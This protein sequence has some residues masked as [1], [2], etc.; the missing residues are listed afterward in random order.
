VNH[1]LAVEGQVR[2]LDLGLV[3]Q[4]LIKIIGKWNL[5]LTGWCRWTI[6]RASPL[7]TQ[8]RIEEMPVSLSPDTRQE[9][10]HISLAVLGSSQG[11]HRVLVDLWP[12]QRSS[13]AQLPKQF[14]MQK[15]DTIHRMYVYLIVVKW[16]K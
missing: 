1:V 4:L 12:Q 8:S 13:T 16:G 3:S 11:V 5:Q 7:K 2:G 9:P 10:S 14:A 6:C 15:H